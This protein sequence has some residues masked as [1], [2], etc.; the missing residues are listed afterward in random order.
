MGR[1]FKVRGRKLSFV[2][3]ILFMAMLAS[4]L[5][6]C[7][8][9]PEVTIGI[10]DQ[11][12]PFGF[13]EGGKYKGFEIDLWKAIAAEAGL[14]YKFKPMAPG[15]MI[16][17]LE[18]RDIDIGLAGLS[19]NRGRKQ[20]V[21]YSTPYFSSGLV[22]VVRANERQIKEPKDLK[23]KVVATKIGTT[24]YE[25][26]VRTKEIKE[27]RAYPDIGD[28]YKAMMNMDADVVIFDAENAYYYVKNEG[29]GRA[30]TVG[31]IL[32]NEQYAIALQTGS[33]YKGRIN[34]AL[35]ELGKNGTY[36]RLYVKWFGHKPKSKPGDK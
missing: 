6:A 16:Q 33:P 4:V 34:N 23:G 17:A 28:A 27:V 8:E 18:T 26:A 7:N 21:E 36:E 11:L 3:L 25:Y 14:R 5:A 15:E 24:A 29:K 22:M 2:R 35:R 1:W 9:Q 20:R 30:K 19:V 32:T 10:E 13:E 31:E 12:Q